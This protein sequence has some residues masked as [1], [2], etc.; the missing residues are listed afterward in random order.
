[1]KRVIAPLSMPRRIHHFII[2]PDGHAA[3]R[4]ESS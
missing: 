1:M 3:L 2:P 4:S